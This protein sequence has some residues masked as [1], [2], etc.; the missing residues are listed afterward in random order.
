MNINETKFAL[1]VIF[2]IM[3]AINLSFCIS[4]YYLVGGENNECSYAAS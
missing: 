1:F 2:V 4:L 3:N